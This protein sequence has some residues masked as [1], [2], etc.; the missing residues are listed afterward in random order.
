MNQRIAITI[1]LKKDSSTSCESFSLTKKH[2]ASSQLIFWGGVYYFYGA[3]ITLGWRL[4]TSSSP[5]QSLTIKV[6]LRAFVI[7]AIIGLKRNIY[8]KQNQCHEV[9]FSLNANCFIT[10]NDLIG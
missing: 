7:L 10:C 6:A 2:G 4:N 8:I 1:K 5:L 9:Q 3:I